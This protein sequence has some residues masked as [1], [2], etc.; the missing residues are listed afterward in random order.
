MCP[1]ISRGP[2]PV[3]GDRRDDDPPVDEQADAAA[4]VAGHGPDDR[5]RHADDAGADRRQQRRHRAQR[6]PHDRLTDPEDPKS[7]A[8]EHAL[9]QRDDADAEQ[10]ADRDVVKLVHERARLRLRQRQHA[11]AEARQ[12]RPFEQ[13]VIRRDRREDDDEH[14]VRRRREQ[15]ADDVG[16]VRDGCVAVA[17]RLLHDAVG[18]LTD[19]MQHARHARRMQPV[20]RGGRVRRRDVRQVMQQLAHD[21]EAHE[22]DEPEPER[23]G[24][25]ADGRGEQARMASIATL[26]PALQRR[27]DDGQHHAEKHRHPDR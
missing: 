16:E 4:D 6:A 12:R 13:Q 5:R 23:D 11:H 26:E 19:A 18:R 8:A 27:R 25:E 7:D 1:S 24:H 2:Q 17:L 15:A 14:E 9:H 3:I 10:R 20:L 21:E 22:H